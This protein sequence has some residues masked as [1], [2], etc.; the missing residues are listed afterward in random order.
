MSLNWEL[1]NIEAKRVLENGVYLIS[2]GG[3]DYNS[4]Q[5][6]NPNATN[7]DRRAFVDLVITKLIEFVKEGKIACCGVGPFRRSGCGEASKVEVCSKPSEYL[8][9]DSAHQV[10]RVNLQ[11]ATL[12]WNAPPTKVNYARR[13]T[14]MTSPFACKASLR[15]DHAQ[16]QFNALE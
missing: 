12:L 15:V 4:F 8:W 10:E 1:G 9:F 11:M 6:R 5:S 2:I 16:P 13:P 7:S 14:P 3:N